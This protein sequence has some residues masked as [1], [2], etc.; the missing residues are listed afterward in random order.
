M[1]VPGQARYYLELDREKGGTTPEEFWS[2]CTMQCPRLPEPNGNSRGG[3]GQEHRGLTLSI[4]ILMSVAGH[5]LLWSQI[6]AGQ[7]I[8][9]RSHLM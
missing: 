8:P 9:L 5:S 6:D 1:E 4:T 3:L 2:S 7:D